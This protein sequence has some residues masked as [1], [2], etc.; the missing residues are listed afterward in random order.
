ME[1]YNCLQ[2]L[3]NNLKNSENN[4]P[5]IITMNNITEI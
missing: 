3:K 4:N 2:N 5:S 1:K